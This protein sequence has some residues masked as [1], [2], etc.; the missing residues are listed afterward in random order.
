MSFYTVDRAQSLIEGTIIDL[1]RED[2]FKN[3]FWTL[4]GFFSQN[5][6]E[7]HLQKIYPDGLSH[8]G[9]RYLKQRHTQGQY[10]SFSHDHSFLLE[11]NIEYVR[12][13]Y[14]PHKP[15]RLQS[16]FACL[17]LEDAETFKSTYGRPED[18][19]YEVQGEIS[20]TADMKL[21]QLGVQNIAGA[22][23]AHRYWNGESTENPF[24]EVILKL[25]VKVL[26]KIS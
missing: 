19:I 11:M 13:A 22:Y 2:A 7:A 14:F 23:L 10:G 12:Q 25:P 20:H 9:W 24:K 16:L 21:T 5:D 6:L 3:P 4:D 18:I 17:S 26:A 1:S 8:H 15:S